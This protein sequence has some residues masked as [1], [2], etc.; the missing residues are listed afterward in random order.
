MRPAL[1]MDQV[2][3]IR[4]EWNILRGRLKIGQFIKHVTR[5]YNLPPLCHNSYY[6]IIRNET[7]HN[8]A[9]KPISYNH[10]PS[11]RRFGG[12]KYPHI[13]PVCGMG[14]CANDPERY[15]LAMTHEEAQAC[16]QEIERHPERDGFHT[17]KAHCR[18]RGNK[19]RYKYINHFRKRELPRHPGGKK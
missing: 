14:V 6:K 2:R 1:D 16:C 19:V 18:P 3:K 12:H 11:Q 8:P 10:R 5:K 9:Y 17:G 13:C 7:Y 15:G 4:S